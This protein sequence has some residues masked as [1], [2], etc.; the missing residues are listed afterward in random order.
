MAACQP[1]G[2]EA[3]G[4]LAR[5]DLVVDHGDPGRGGKRRVAVASRH[6]IEADHGIGELEVFAIGQRFGGGKIIAANEPPI[7]QER[8]KPV[9][10]DGGLRGADGTR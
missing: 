6:E 9:A 8:R 10:S 7:D 4:E 2:H 3:H 5:H 1:L